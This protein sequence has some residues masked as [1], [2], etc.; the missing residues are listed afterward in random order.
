MAASTLPITPGSGA[1]IATHTISVGP[2]TAHCSRVVIN[3]SSGNN[4]V[5]AKDSTLTDGTQKTEVTVLPALVAGSAQIGAVIPGVKVDNAYHLTAVIAPS[6]LT[7]GT[8]YFY[9][10]NP[11]AAK[12]VLIKR[13]RLALSFIGTPASSRSVYALQRTSVAAASGGTAMTIGKRQ[14]AAGASV[15]TDMQFANA[16]LT[17]A[18]ITFGDIPLYAAHLNQ[19]LEPAPAVLDIASTP[20]ML[21]QNEGLALRASGAI[22]SGSAV[23]L[24]IEW[25][26]VDV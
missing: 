15:V 11:S 21:A 9:M 4:I 13:I 20:L 19:L 10:R 24:H 8:T 2:D 25:A 16:G 22:V 1:L 17:T 5:P 3:D 6:T 7:D 23:L 18:G 26:E 12:N 14:S